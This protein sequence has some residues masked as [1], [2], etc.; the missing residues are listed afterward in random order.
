MFWGAEGAGAKWPAG[1]ASILVLLAILWA[2]SLGVVYLLK[3]NQR[4]PA[5]PSAPSLARETSQS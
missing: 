5:A 4:A 2:V 1:D 3:Q